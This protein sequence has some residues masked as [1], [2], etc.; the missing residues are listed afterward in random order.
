MTELFKTTKPQGKAHAID[1]IVKFQIDDGIESL[2]IGGKEALA[3]LSYDKKG[4]VT[5]HFNADKDKIDEIVSLVPFVSVE[6][7]VVN[8]KHTVTLNLDMREF[9][10]K[11]EGS[12]LVVVKKTK[13][14]ITLDLTKIQEKFDEI[15]R[16]LGEHTEKIKEAEKKIEENGN[17]IA[18]N[19]SKI[20]ENKAKIQEIVNELVEVGKK[21]AKNEGDIAENL[22]KIKSN[23]TELDKQLAMIEDVTSEV[24]EAKKAISKNADDIVEQAKKIG[25]LQEKDKNLE[26]R[27]NFNEN[28]INRVEQDLAVTDSKV[29]TIEGKVD[30][31]V[32]KLKEKDISLDGEISEL[33]VKDSELESKIVSV[34]GKLDDF[35]EEN[36]QAI[37]GVKRSIVEE[38]NKL[39]EF[40]SDYSTDKSV[41]EQ[42]LRENS[43]KVENLE[44]DFTE[45]QRVQDERT[46]NYNNER[47]AKEEQLENSAR[48]IIRILG[49]KKPSV[50]DK[51]E[52]E[53]MLNKVNEKINNGAEGLEDLQDYLNEL[54]TIFDGGVYDFEKIP[55]LN[56]ARAIR[57]VYDDSEVQ[58][59]VEKVKN[60]YYFNAIDLFNRLQEIEQNLSDIESTLD[61]S[62]LKVKSFN[63]NIF[64]ILEFGEKLDTFQSVLGETKEFKELN[65]L[66]T[67][68][69]KVYSREHYP[70]TAFENFNQ[71]K[72]EYDNKDFEKLVGEI[73]DYVNI[74][75]P[76]ANYM[77]DLTRIYHEIRHLIDTYKIKN[78]DLSIEKDYNLLNSENPEL[79]G[80]LMV[81]LSSYYGLLEDEYL[82]YGDIMTNKYYSK[83]KILT[84]NNITVNNEKLT[85]K[86]DFTTKILGYYNS[87]KSIGK[88]LKS[89]LFEDTKINKFYISNIGTQKAINNT[90]VCIYIHLRAYNKIPKATN[91]AVLNV[92]K[93]ST[94]TI[95]LVK[96]N[97]L[98]QA[99]IEF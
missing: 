20:N 73:I 79:D 17:K 3:D 86:D 25:E 88:L 22:E 23:K 59:I 33:K 5:L 61:I 82:N 74:N 92:T 44:S 99:V 21:I 2:T 60:K 45:G 85:L 27:I 51:T 94:G 29:N 77:D 10:I 12:E 6:S 90:V 75:L 95:M 66:L 89:F 1:S 13:T 19:L 11:V 57:K 7:D 35:K 31:E 87:D 56:Y 47:K 49:V 52:I 28:N 96:M 26:R 84:N 68:L 72:K 8:D 58:A 24:T 63:D 30:S 54:K 62:H 55:R 76:D 15:E 34:Q 37:E 71:Y 36:T 43:T 32:G 41:V 46:E 98:G 50:Q 16:K 42:K 48:E 67:N 38:S 91:C 4:N 97:N 64:K 93:V 83:A 53:E 69:Y 80:R 65:E 40:K 81:F 39:E 78:L 9:D 14:D 18:E 70:T